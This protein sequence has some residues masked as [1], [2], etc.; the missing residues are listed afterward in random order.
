MPNFSGRRSR[1]G[2]KRDFRP[3]K[4]PRQPTSAE[5][6]RAGLKFLGP[7]IRETYADLALLVCRAAGVGNGGQPPSLPRGAI[8][9]ASISAHTLGCITRVPSG[10]WKTFCMGRLA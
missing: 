2:G 1:V 9:S 6:L 3:L 10:I 7:E 5:L 4:L 8:A